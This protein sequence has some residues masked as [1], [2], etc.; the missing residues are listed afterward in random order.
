[1]MV[2]F[3]QGSLPWQGIKARDK[4]KSALV[5]EQKQTITAEELCKGL[6]VEFAEFMT[7]VYSLHHGEMPK[8]AKLRRK[9]RRLAKKE[10]MEYD[11]VYDWTIRV[12]LQQA[13]ED[14]FKDK[15]V[16]GVEGD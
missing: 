9:F 1:M 11:N 8:Y 15:A 2:Y 4:D 16:D 12:Y 6:P 3:L 14:R 7:T 13:G 10:G 5:L